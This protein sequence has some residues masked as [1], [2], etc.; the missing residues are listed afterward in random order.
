MT[1]IK[2]GR[3]AGKNYQQLIDTYIGLSDAQ[4]E[5][6][7]RI[8]TDFEKAPKNVQSALIA[9]RLFTSDGEWTH[10]ASSVLNLYVQIKVGSFNESDGYLTEHEIQMLNDPA[11]I[12]RQ[13]PS[14]KLTLT[15]G[16][17]KFMRIVLQKP[18][19]SI[20]TMEKIFAVHLFNDL[21]SRRLL[22]REHDSHRIYPENKG[23]DLIRACIAAVDV[24]PNKK[25]GNK[26][27]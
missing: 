15:S 8:P 5:V 7:S 20:F 26:N 13:Q 10:L 21:I 4:L 12:S 3:Q 18:G 23:V 6:I 14:K 27:G 16:H 19:I 24:S 1:N 22:S 11:K 2:A 17:I 9:R 25:K